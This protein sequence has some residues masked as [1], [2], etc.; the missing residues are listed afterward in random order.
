MLL[1]CF[2]NWFFFNVVLLFFEIYQFPFLLET[3]FVEGKYFSQIWQPVPG[4]PGLSLLASSAPPSLY[5]RF[6]S[7][8]ET[9]QRIN[10]KILFRGIRLGNILPSNAALARAR[11]RFAS[12]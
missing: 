12:E 1:V 10:I 11:A 9:S 5:L 2:L 4:E 8:Q 7:D 6:P 3:N